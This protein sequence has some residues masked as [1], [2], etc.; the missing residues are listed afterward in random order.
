MSTLTIAA[1]LTLIACLVPKGGFWI[2]DNGCKYLQ[3]RAL[4]AKGPWDAAIDWPGEVIDPAFRFIP[5]RP[6]FVHI[7]NGKLF[8]QYSPVFAL[9][10][11]WPY[12][13]FGIA[14]LYL[15]PLLGGILTIEGVRRLSGMLAQLYAH[16][17]AQSAIDA[18]L[19]SRAALFGAI[20]AGLATPIMFY[21]AVFW[22]H[23]PSIACVTWA[24]VFAVKR[25][26]GG[27]A[28]RIIL[29]AILLALSIY[30]RDDLYLL[31]G[32][33]TGLYLVSRHT[34][35]D[36]G[37]FL[38]VGIATCIPLWVYQ[39]IAIGHP[40]GFHFHEIGPLQA[41]WSAYFADR[42]PVIRNLFLNFL[43]H[44]RASIMAALPFLA[45]LAAA[46]RKPMAVSSP[47]FLLMSL[48]ACAA[49]LAALVDFFA[50]A[51]PMR[52]LMVAHSF[53][54]A[55]PVLALAFF[56]PCPE[57]AQRSPM[58]I[59]PA[60]WLLRLILVYFLAYALVSPLDNT[61]G[62]HWGC[63][64]LMPGYPLLASLAGVALARVLWG[65]SVRRWVRSCCVILLLS[66]IALQAYSVALLYRRQATSAEFN[67]MVSA[68][69][70]EVI[71]SDA[72]FIG[73]ELAPIYAYRPIFQFNGLEQ[74]NELQALLARH[75]FQNM[76]LIQDLHTGATPPYVTVFDDGIGLVR[77][78]LAVQQVR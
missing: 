24:A 30:F 49:S 19:S 56:R 34:R 4:E 6:P 59:D 31:A 62:V 23:T 29:A 50:A 71:V 22:E 21:S 15:L 51:L 75:G 63:R 68:S 7:V 65:R 38:I 12:R 60:R 48:F 74:W 73:Q 14:G 11:L 1:I 78:G 53:F 3:V 61:M 25:L 17:P 35:R 10:S 54:V 36:A 41:G 37:L 42:A 32:V 64:F 46:A 69:E 77:V 67:R 58:R 8:V 52:Y 45:C 27:P 55:S 5:F 43:S 47:V 9:V 16:E 13:V 72:W 44:P 28:R 2:N 20:I 40:L 66:S 76:L 18:P 26:L 57:H 39:Y 33:W 70:G